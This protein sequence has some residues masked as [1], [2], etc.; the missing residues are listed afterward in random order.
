MIIIINAIFL[1]NSSPATSS[2]RNVK[3]CA[4]F[5]CSTKT[6]QS[7]RSPSLFL[8]IAVLLTSN[9]WYRNRLPNLVIANWLWRIRR[10][11]WVRDRDLKKHRFRVQIPVHGKLPVRVAVISYKFS[12]GAP[13]PKRPQDEMSYGK[14]R[15]RRRKGAGAKA[16]QVCHRCGEEGG[17]TAKVSGVRFNEERNKHN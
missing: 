6:T 15:A 12:P 14:R 9:S 10:R 13:T 16:Q 5:Y 11:I 17:A 1:G 4:T 3:C 2:P 7:S 8:S